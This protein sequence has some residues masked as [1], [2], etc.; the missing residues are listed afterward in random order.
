MP[1]TTRVY[2]FHQYGNPD[3]LQLD[4][5]PLAEPKAGE[6]ASSGDEFKSSRSAMDGKYLC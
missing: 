6:G 5:L 4:S 3:V 1:T 2:R